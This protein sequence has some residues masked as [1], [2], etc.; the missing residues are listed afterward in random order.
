LKRSRAKAVKAAFDIIG[1]PLA[2]KTLGIGA[3]R[4]R[5]RGIAL[6]GLVVVGVGGAAYLAV[7]GSAEQVVAST[8]AKRNVPAPAGTS[9]R[10][11]ASK[12][13]MALT[14]PPALAAQSTTV[15]SS[16]APSAVPPPPAMPRAT[17]GCVL[18]DPI[19]GMTVT[20]EGRIFI[21]RAYAHFN[22]QIGHTNPP[23][24]R[25]EHP[26][27]VTWTDVPESREE[28]AEVALMA[29]DDVTRAAL[30]E[31]AHVKLGGSIA[32]EMT[33]WHARP[34]VLFVEVVEALR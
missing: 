12:E 31:G 23:I 32:R 15:V 21:D 9:P 7:G 26:Q 20:L 33:A 8:T 10:A 17:S 30:R 6:G 29:G 2:K 13:A 4:R 22:P 28:G 25:V 34:V 14:P 18:V 24:L 1:Q 3:S 27:C 19:Q 11:V 16:S 5:I